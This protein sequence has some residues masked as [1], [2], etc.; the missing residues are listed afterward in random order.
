M[1]YRPWDSCSC[2]AHLESCAKTQRVWNLLVNDLCILYSKWRPESVGAEGQL[3]S[4]AAENT[5][6][7]TRQPED[8][9]VPKGLVFAQR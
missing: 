9:Q 7:V 1:Y 2:S 5:V 6:M 8:A 4:M 3:E